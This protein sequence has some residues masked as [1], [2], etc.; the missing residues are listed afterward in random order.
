MNDI[1]TRTTIAIE[2]KSVPDTIQLTHN[3]LHL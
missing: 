1:Q 3:W 2:S